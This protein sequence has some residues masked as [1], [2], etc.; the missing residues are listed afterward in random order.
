[1]SRNKA[2]LSR[3]PRH[4]DLRLFFRGVCLGGIRD[5]VGAFPW[6]DGSFTPSPAAAAFRDFFRWMVDEGNRG[7]DPPFDEAL[8]DEA[9]WSVER[10][11]GSRVGISVPAV[12]EES[13][14]ISWRWR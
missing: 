7:E 3:M 2:G 6:M 11:D 1:M 4:F 8:L 12:L 10:A 5:P 14:S 13:G 9:N